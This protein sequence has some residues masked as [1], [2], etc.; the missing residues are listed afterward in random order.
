MDWGTCIQAL[1]REYAGPLI[2]K[3]TGLPG[4]ENFESGLKCLCL[5][6][7]SLLSVVG[8]EKTPDQSN[9]LTGV[10]FIALDKE[11]WE[12]SQVQVVNICFV[13]HSAFGKTFL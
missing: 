6:R 11:T 8:L 12:N 5:A 10:C 2:K 4:C 3:E 1:C 7:A 9:T 13:G